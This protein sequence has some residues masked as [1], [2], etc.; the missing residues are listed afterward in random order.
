[1]KLSIII[2]VYNVEDY[3]EKCILSLEEQDIPSGDY[4]IIVINDGSL[5]NSR[6]VILKLVRQFD[7]IILIDQEN[8]GVSLAR[9][10]GIEKATGEYLL[11]IDPDDYVEANSFSRLIKAAEGNNAQVVFLGYR[12]LNADNSLKKENFF[13]EEKGRMYAGINAYTVSRGDGTTD[14]DRSWAIL[15]NRDFINNNQLRNI[16]DVP[17]LE[18][19]EFIARV[20]C[21]AERCIFEGGPFYF[22]TTRKGSAT[23][24]G[25]FYSD[26]A[27]DGFMKA[28]DNLKQFKQS[29]PL[30]KAQQNFINQPITKFTLLIVQ[31][32]TGKGRYSKYKE[33]KEQIKMQRLNKIE[34]KGCSF[35]YYKYGLIYNL[36]NDLF[37]Y[38]W[39]IRLLFISIGSK[40]K[41]VFN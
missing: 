27:I 19:G 33:I 14:P 10:A 6:E 25:L 38:V 1:M 13:A 17:Y 40:I 30:S 32:C 41:F 2:P 3:I 39:N 35:F 12:F 34:I 37:Y 20:L 26:R 4:E 23:N 11:F 28:A 24:S 18:D 15:Y 36:S 8:K 29:Y 22:R 7:N 9:N 21:L 16:A 5:D 31:A